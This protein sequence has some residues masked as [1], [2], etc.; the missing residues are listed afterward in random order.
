MGSPLSPV[1]ADLI[2]QNLESTILNDL[3]YKPTFYY[4]YVDDIALSV[5]FSQL[6]SLLAKFNSFHHRLRFTMEIDGEGDRLNFL[7]L[8]IIKQDNTLI[9]DWFRKPTFSG[10]F[11]NY[12]SHHPFTHKRGTMYGLIDR[13]IR[14]SHPR[15]HE[16][17]FDH[18]IKVLLDNGYPLDLI[19]SSIRRR[20]YTRSYGNRTKSNEQEKRASIPYF[21]IPY[22]SCVSKNFIHFFKNISFSK[23]AFSCYNKLNKF[24]KVLKDVLPVSSRSN[25]VYKINCLDCD[26]SYVGQTK[27]ALSIRVNEH[28]NHIRRNSTQ[29]SV[30]TD[31]RLNSKHEFDWDN[32]RVL[33]KETN[34]NKRLIA[35]MIYIKKQKQGLNAQIDTELLDPIYNNLFSPTL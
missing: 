4:K 19:F 5:P 3:N 31:H 35:E 27:R 26:A 10:R 32:A 8:T 33:D 21:V 1:V 12:H 7:D 28:R 29:P 17:N 34:Y 2:L 11:L 25:V 24:I 30:I 23:L 6:H 16:N 18:I 15:F 13:V 22:V 14:L 20:L 9:F